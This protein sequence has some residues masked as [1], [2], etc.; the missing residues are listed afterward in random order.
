MKNT[1]SNT[2]SEAVLYNNFDGLEVSFKGFLPQQHIDFLAECKE[3]AQ[4]KKEPCAVTLGNITIKVFEQGA[5]GG[6]AFKFTTGE[7]GETWF[8][9]RSVKN[10]WNIRCSVNSACFIDKD[11]NQLK[12]HLYQR[13]E[14]FGATVL[15]ASISRIDYAVD[16]LAPEFILRPENFVAHARTKGD[17]Y[18]SIQN[19]KVNTVTMGSMPNKQVTIYNKS[20][21][22]K[23]KKKTYWLDTWEVNDK[24]QVWRVELR[25]G[26]KYLRKWNI[27]SWES[28]EEKAG[29][30]FIH[31]C[32]GTR[33]VTDI[34]EN[35]RAARCRN[36]DIWTSVVGI[37]KGSLW[38]SI[39]GLKPC[40]IK[41]YATKT[42]DNQL[43]MQLGGIATRL[44]Y[45]NGLDHKNSHLLA[46]M[47]YL[48]V[49]E[50][51]RMHRDKVSRNISRAE[52]AYCFVPEE[53][54][55]SLPHY[56]RNH[57]KGEKSNGMY[58]KICA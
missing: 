28:L 49:K 53:E 45:L 52:D 46:D 36:H 48:A 14:D 55:Q 47:T 9:K 18:T 7:D 35:K 8:I 11:F 21:E 44:A 34:Q 40:T 17:I 26:K 23:D 33:Y 10:D 43:T 22:I 51:T 16:F 39:N 4:N 6:Y 30:L 5:K 1:R 19:R 58:D 31:I 3:R 15:D 41:K 20:K 24:A 12:N 42:A 54:L 37:I 32:N 29:D 50:Y 13:L 56:L 25:A 27:S 38:D 57:Y 2:D